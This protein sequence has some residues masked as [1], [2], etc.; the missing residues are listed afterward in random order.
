MIVAGRWRSHR[1]KLLIF[2]QFL[3]FDFFLPYTIT[4][5]PLTPTINSHFLVQFVLPYSI[6]LSRK[7]LIIFPSHMSCCCKRGKK[8]RREIFRFFIFFHYKG[9]RFA[10]YIPIFI[11]LRRRPPANNDEQSSYTNNN[12]QNP[13]ILKWSS[14]FSSTFPPSPTSQCSSSSSYCCFHHLLELELCE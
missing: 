6:A 7:N 10:F 5:I 14:I 9:H 11:R 12:P 1:E 13:I 4:F 2:Y 8:R 3:W